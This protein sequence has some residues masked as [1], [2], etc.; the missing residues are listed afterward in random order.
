MINTIK[1]TVV[2]LLIAASAILHAQNTQSTDAFKITGKVK[3]EKVITLAD[4]QRYKTIEL[5]DVNVTCSPKKEDMVK[6]VK[7]VL[8]RDILD[9]VAFEYEKSYMLN[10]YYFLFVGSDGYK[11]VFSFNEVYNTEV[12]N[13]L[14]VVTERDGK[15]ISEM[16]NRI[17]ILS[18]KDIKAGPRN[19]K[20]LSEIVVCRAQQ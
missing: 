14:F 5:H 17:M 3:N 18:A 12:G 20:W 13:N 15:S 7:A 1:T 19:I 2:L 10:E 4:L 9:S 16:E 8:L 11:I 6:S